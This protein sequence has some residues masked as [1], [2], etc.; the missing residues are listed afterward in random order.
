MEMLIHA[1]VSSRSD[2]TN[3][4]FFLLHQNRS[5]SPGSHPECSRLPTL[6]TKTISNNLW[7]CRQQIICFS[8]RTVSRLNTLANSLDLWTAMDVLLLCHLPGPLGF[9][10]F[11]S[12]VRT[13]RGWKRS[14][15]HYNSVYNSSSSTQRISYQ[16]VWRFVDLNQMRDSCMRRAVCNSIH[17]HKTPPYTRTHLD[18]GN[19]TPRVSLSSAAGE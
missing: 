6:P 19:T 4:F 17:M 13:F 7:L 8:H 10:V 2:C 15:Q 5:R 14:A 11:R 12:I 9:N 18:T 3:V 16:P 1:F